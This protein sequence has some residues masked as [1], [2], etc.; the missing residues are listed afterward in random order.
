MAKKKKQY[1]AVVK[2]RVPGIYRTWFGAGG[3]A[4]QVQGLDDAR[5]RGFFTQEEMFAWLAD[6]PQRM[7]KKEAPE[8]AALA[9]EN[10]G[11]TPSLE[12]EARALLAAGK[13]VIFTD[14]SA[15][16]HS[17]CGGYG[18]VVRS[19]TARKELSGG[20]RGTTNNRMELTAVIRALETLEKPSDV[21]VFSDSQYVVRAMRE[22]WIENWN[23]NGWARDKKQELK[24]ADLWQQLYALDKKHHVT[25][26]WVRGH[27]GTRE[28][29]RCDRL[30]LAALQKKGLPLDNGG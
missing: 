2:G 11:N 20:F 16:T 26:Q 14:G 8:L 28:N 10:K 6:L 18:A 21:V 3:A 27:S 1:Y 13:V 7:L 24:N 17:R 5:Y 4:E 23:A 25:Y 15:D 30:A 19:G 9:A 29:E 12:E 22:S